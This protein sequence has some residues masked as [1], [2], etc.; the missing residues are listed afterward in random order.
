MSRG[1]RLLPALLIA[2]GATGVAVNIALGRAIG[3]LLHGAMLALG[4]VLAV[5]RLL[6]IKKG[7]AVHLDHL[8]Y[9]A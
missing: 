3:A 2:L 5:S 1:S 9:K 4:L 8:N 7:V 6:C